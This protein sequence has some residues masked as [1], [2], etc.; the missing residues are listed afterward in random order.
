MVQVIPKQFHQE[1]SRLGQILALSSLVLIAIVLGGY[2]VLR[3]QTAKADFSLKD[4]K[5]QLSNIQTQQDLE[6][7]GKIFEYRKKIRDI[8]LLLSQRKR[9]GDF[10]NF[11]S[12]FVH[13]NLY[14]TELNLDLDKGKATLVGMSSDFPSIGQQIDIFQKQDFTQK[15]ELMDVSLE[16]Q[17]AIKFT[18]DISLF[19][20]E[21]QT[22]K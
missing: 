11:L 16:D 1:K 14:F 18:L 6:I 4:V 21:N 15:V 13:P 20:K 10:L 8:K 19:S 12:N 5:S 3:A 7:K 2:F 9:A 22:K 17:N